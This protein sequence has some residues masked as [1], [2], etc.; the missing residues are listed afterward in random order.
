MAY[1]TAELSYFPPDCSLCEYV[2]KQNVFYV[3]IT[4]KICIFNR[5][6]SSGLKR[7]NCKEQN[8]NDEC[9]KNIVGMTFDCASFYKVYVV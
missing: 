7:A 6:R 9:F 4:S 2:I 1:E 8:N 3:Y 5:G